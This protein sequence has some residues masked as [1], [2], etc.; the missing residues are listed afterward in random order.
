MVLGTTGGWSDGLHLSGTEGLWYRGSELPWANQASVAG[1]KHTSCSVTSGKILRIQTTVHRNRLPL[2]S[3]TA[4]S[5]L[6]KRPF[7]LRWMASGM[8][9]SE[10]PC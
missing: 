4:G 3:G 2:K 9:K 5:E 1:T 6:L 10:A 8:S 7:F